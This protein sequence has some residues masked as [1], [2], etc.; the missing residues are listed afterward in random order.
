[1]SKTWACRW[2][3]FV[4]TIRTNPRCR[5]RKRPCAS[6]S[7][8][9]VKL[10]VIKA[11]LLGAQPLLRPHLPRT[12]RRRRRQRKRGQTLPA[13]RGVGPAFVLRG[14]PPPPKS[15]PSKIHRDRLPLLQT[16][17]PALLLPRTTNTSTTPTPLQDLSPRP[18]RGSSTT[19]AQ[20]PPGLL[21]RDA[22]VKRL[23]ALLEAHAQRGLLLPARVLHAHGKEARAVGRGLDR[24]GRGVGRR[25]EER[26]RGGV[27]QQDVDF[28]FCLGFGLVGGCCGGGG[29][30][31]G[32][33]GLEDA[34]AGCEDVAAWVGGPGGGGVAGCCGQGVARD[35]VD[36]DFGGYVWGVVSLALFLCF[37]FQLVD[38]GRR[39]VDRML[40]AAVGGLTENA[41]NG[42]G[43]QGLARRRVD[44][45]REIHLGLR[46]L[47]CSGIGKLKRE[48]AQTP[49][50]QNTGDA[51]TARHWSGMSGPAPGRVPGSGPA[52]CC[53]TPRS[54]PHPSPRLTHS[55]C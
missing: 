23:A 9:L 18:R 15:R 21:Q 28:Y 38:D 13:P 43:G 33:G 36:V 31:V 50:E 48:N 37:P 12:R 52:A 19:P 20:R 16:Q 17:I 27:L 41:H 22:K 32:E 4:V 53:A 29:G 42:V 40:D 47:F 2:S 7:S 45:S 35:G 5:L 10:P 51:L 14:R 3:K 24:R 6:P 39:M 8:K 44:G 55:K 49:K 34:Q 25:G 54:T 26:A 1:M 46:C 11:Q 30:G